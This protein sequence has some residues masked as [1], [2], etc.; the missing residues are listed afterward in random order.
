MLKR[1]AD[2]GKLRETDRGL[3]LSFAVV[4]VV[5]A[6]AVTGRCSCWEREDGWTI[7]CREPADI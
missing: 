4:V 7:E 2:R 5:D 1:G 3:D 6:G